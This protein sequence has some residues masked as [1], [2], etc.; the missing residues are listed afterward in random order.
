MSG[1]DRL[2]L[3]LGGGEAAARRRLD[4]EAE[5]LGFAR[6]ARRDGERYRVEG[7]AEPL[8]PVPVGTPEELERALATSGDRTLLEW[9][10][11]RIIPLEQALA[12]APAGRRVAVLARTAAEVPAALGALERGAALV[13]LEVSGLPELRR[14]AAYVDRDPVLRI[15]WWPARVVRV[16]PAGTSE[17]VLVDTTRLLGARDGL[18]V[19]SAARFLFPIASEAVGSSFSGPRP[20]RVNAGAPHSYV[21]MADGTTRYLS[22]LRG[23]D[24]VLVVRST[25]TPFAARVGRVKIERRPMVLVEAAVRGAR[26]TVFL[27][28]AETV[29]FLGARA[30]RPVTEVRTGDRLRVAELPA[31]RHLGTAV[32]ESIEER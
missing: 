5:R 13:V 12:N 8:I 27:Q 15:R 1:V 30:N 23:G 4:E 9:T 21:L 17:R 22:E 6:R 26:A 19:G 29:R 7:L 32:S 2:A 28:E 18:L 14:L 24:R 11:D 31:A 10:G 16:E 25:G 20:F 3:C